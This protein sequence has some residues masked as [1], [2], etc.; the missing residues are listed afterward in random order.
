M[1]RSRR[2]PFSG[3]LKTVAGTTAIQNSND[4]S[5]PTGRCFSDYSDFK[6]ETGLKEI[7]EAEKSTKKSLVS[8]VP[9]VRRC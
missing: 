7:Y 2:L 9:L 4:Y 6:V 5:L 8:Q 1:T 3:Q